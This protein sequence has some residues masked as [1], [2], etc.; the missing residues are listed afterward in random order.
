E[1][2]RAVAE[3]RRRRQPDYVNPAFILRV[4]MS[5]P[6][7]E[8]NWEQL[9]LT[10]L[11]SD[12]DKTLI[13]FSNA[14]DMAEFRQ[15][16]AAYSQGPRVNR[17]NAPYA[18]FLNHIETIGAVGP[19]DRIGIRFREAGLAT[20]EDLQDQELYLVD[21]ELWELGGRQARTRKLEEL[22]GY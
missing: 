7:M 21:I 1:L 22:I 20:P 4:Q 8:E 13:L 18:W 3:Q 6:L 12:E 11:S 2:N 19:R 15:R 5:G 14:D 10:L 17:K 16:L 9:G